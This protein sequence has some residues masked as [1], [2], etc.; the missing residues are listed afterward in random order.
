MSH[1]LTVLFDDTYTF[2]MLFFFSAGSF[3]AGLLIRAS[4]GTKQKKNILKLENEM[5]K[6]HSRILELEAKVS[7]LTDENAELIKFNPH[8]IGLKVS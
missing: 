5:L 4:I 6:N 8:K 2:A 1:N 7:Q 3:A